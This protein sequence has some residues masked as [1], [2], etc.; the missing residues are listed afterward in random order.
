MI[1]RMLARL[2]W[3]EPCPVCPDLRRAYVNELSRL[4]SLRTSLD[5]WVGQAIRAR[6]ERDTLEKERVRFGAESLNIRDLL[7]RRIVEL[8]RERDDL[9]RIGDHVRA[10]RDTAHAAL[11]RRDAI[12]RLE[13]GAPRRL[14]KGKKN[15]RR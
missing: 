6:Q 12:D 10:E 1:R 4:A 13:A 9:I 8:E 5:H 15:G 14:Q 3:P 7:D 2:V 11:S